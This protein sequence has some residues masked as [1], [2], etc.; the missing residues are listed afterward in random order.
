[1]AERP[2]PM[3]ECRA[4][5]CHETNQHGVPMAWVE[6]LDRYGFTL[7]TTDMFDGGA[8]T[9]INYCPFCGLRLQTEEHDAKIV[10][11]IKR[12]IVVVKEAE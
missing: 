12:C 4:R 10:P 2:H 11:P 1:M 7:E 8:S 6:Y 9:A 3:P 5:G